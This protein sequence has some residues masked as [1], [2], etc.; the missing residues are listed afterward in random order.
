MNVIWVVVMILSDQSILEL[1]KKGE[2]IIKP[3]NDDLVGPSSVDLR[4]GNEFLVFER[5]R[6]DVIDPKQPLEDL[7]RKIFVENGDF[8]VI[9]PGE[10]I[11]ATTLEYIKLPDYIAARI[12]GRSSL[13]RLGIVVHSTGGFVD[14]GFEGQLTLEM[15][16]LNRIPVKLYPGM[17]IAQLAFILQDKPSQVPY[18]KR[19]SSKYHKQKGPIPSK[20]YRDFFENIR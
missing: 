7:T 9:H 1:I 2:I 8:F 14:A 20:I 6:I 16:N 4:L 10:F 17:K 18:G 13:A 19:P 3:F 12:E 11:L 5:A 15:S